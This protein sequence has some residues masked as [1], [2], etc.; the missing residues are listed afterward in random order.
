MSDDGLSDLGHLAGVATGYTT[1]YGE[2]PDLVSN[3][4][5]LPWR[6][7]PAGGGVASANDLVKFFDALRSG[8]LLSPAMLE[9]ATTRDAEGWGLG[10][11]ANSGKYR[12]FGH[13]GGS[14]GMDV[15]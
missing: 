2:E 7:T 9:L 5:T 15:A 1:L 13:G 6:G 10:F 3:L 12:S 8:K 4:D 14:Y 11:V